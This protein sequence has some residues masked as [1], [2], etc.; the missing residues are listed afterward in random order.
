MGGGGEQTTETVRKV[1]QILESSETNFKIIMTNVFN[2]LGENRE[3]FIRK[4]KFIKRDKRTVHE[5][6]K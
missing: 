5:G 3:N 4:L 1:S 6:H 2:K